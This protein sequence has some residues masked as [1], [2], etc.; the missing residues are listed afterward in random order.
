MR[1]PCGVVSPHPR[2]LTG[3]AAWSWRTQ[4]P[5]IRH[6]PTCRLDTFSI[7][8]LYLR[9]AIRRQLTLEPEP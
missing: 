2:T 8:D 3:G 1:G 6:C 7:D 5:V 4:L 9:N